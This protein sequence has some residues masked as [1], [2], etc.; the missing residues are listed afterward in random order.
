MIGTKPPNHMHTY[1]HT[2]IH[3]TYWIY[4]GN[5]LEIQRTFFVFSYK[6]FRLKRLAFVFSM[7]LGM[8]VGVPD[9]TDIIKV[10]RVVP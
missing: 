8:A 10:V 2:Y 9:L 3:I 5:T 6:D 4:V 1:I 7:Y